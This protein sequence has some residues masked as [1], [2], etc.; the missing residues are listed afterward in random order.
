MRHLPAILI[1]PVAAWAQGGVT[2]PW[3]I[4]PT[5]RSLASETARLR[6]LLE[7]INPAEWVNKGAPEAYV[8]QHGSLKAE[9][10]YLTAKLGELEKDPERMTPTLET[11]FRL[12][13]VES[14][15]NSMSEGVRRYQNPALADLVL[16][17]ISESENNRSRLRSYLVELVSTKEHELRIMDGEAQRCRGMI[18]KQPPARPAAKPPAAK[19]VPAAKPQ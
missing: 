16:G 2:P 17:V 9:L 15:L 7:Q 10:G 6:P 18:L 1:L 8:A 13:A 3:G 11:Y 14:L 5:L 19:P 12:Q 4:Q